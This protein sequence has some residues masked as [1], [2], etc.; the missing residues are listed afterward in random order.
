MT[1]LE[2]L[3][4]SLVKGEYSSISLTWNEDFS[5]NYE[6]ADTWYNSDSDL[7]DW[8]SYDEK[9]KA[10]TENSVWSLQ[11]Y[12]DTPIGS[13]IIRASSLEAIIQYLKAR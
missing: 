9:V 1:E 10:I 5:F 12:P 7:Q 11:W 4:K 2:T 8:V 3:L 13:C 6:T